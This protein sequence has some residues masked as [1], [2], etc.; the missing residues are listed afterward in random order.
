[1]SRLRITVL[2]ALLAMAATGCD[3]VADMRRQPRA[4]PFAGSAFFADGSTARPVPAGAVTRD[5]VVADPAAP[6]AVTPPPAVT[7]ALLER[8]RTRYGVHCAVCHGADGYGAGMIVQRGFP[9]PPSFH[10]ARSRSLPDA[11]IYGVITNGLGKMP[12]YGVDIPPEDR[13]A[14]IAYL[15][16]LQLSQNARPADVPAGELPAAA[17]ASANTRDSSREVAQ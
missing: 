9:Q 16:A 6:A 11:Y 7:R 10:D 2:G 13:W 8:G 3:E 15:R 5:G 14:V 1:M 17:D 4:N 12:A